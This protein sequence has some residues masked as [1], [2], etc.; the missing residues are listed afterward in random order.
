MLVVAMVL[1]RVRQSATVLLRMELDLMA[2]RDERISVHICPDLLIS[3][4]NEGVAGFPYSGKL[5]P[6][7]CAIVGVMLR[8]SAEECVVVIGCGN[9]SFSTSGL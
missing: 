1:I 9:V 5:C 6:I 7:Y 3:S 4:L 8:G 2:S